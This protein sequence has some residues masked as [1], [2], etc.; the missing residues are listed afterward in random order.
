MAHRITAEQ[1]SAVVENDCEWTE[2]RVLE[3]FAKLPEPTLETILNA[4]AG[5]ATWV[6]WA[7]ANAVVW[8]EAA[9]WAL[10]AA[11]LT[12]NQ[13]EERSQQIEDLLAALDT[14]QRG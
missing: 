5:W 7:R 11:S 4:E 6:A 8:A 10:E 12:D 2:G 9:A 3:R 14:C 13:K 1:I